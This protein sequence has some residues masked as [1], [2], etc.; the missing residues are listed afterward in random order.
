MMQ[1]E[2]PV[3]VLESKEEASCMMFTMFRQ[4]LCHHHPV[5]GL[6]HVM[7]TTAGHPRDRRPV[8]LRVTPLVQQ[9]RRQPIQQLTHRRRHQRPVHPLHLPWALLL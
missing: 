3:A 5:K 6:L 2:V 8:T 4:D 1:R 7:P 9:L